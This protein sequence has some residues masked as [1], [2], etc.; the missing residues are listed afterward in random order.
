MSMRRKPAPFPIFTVAMAM[1]CA[2]A[3]AAPAAA[4]TGGATLDRTVLPNGQKGPYLKRSGAERP[5][6]MAR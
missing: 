2:A 3:I 1:L 6:T 5:A 4:Q